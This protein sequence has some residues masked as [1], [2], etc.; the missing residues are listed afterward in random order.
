[1]AEM[2]HGSLNY[3]E[4]D[5]MN[6]FVLT[7]KPQSKDEESL[8]VPQGE[9]VLTED[10]DLVPESLQSAVILLVEDN[11]EML[12]F[13]A[14]KLRQTYAVETALNGKEA[15]NV[16]HEKNI[17]LV[18]SDIMMP[19]MDGLELC[20]RIKE[21]I[22]L[23][24]IPVILLTAKNDLDSK[25]QGLK[26]GADA[27][28][29]KPFAFKY[30]VAQITSI[31]ENRRRGMDAFMRK[32]F[33]PTQTLGMSKADEKLMDKIV[34][35]IEE[36]IDDTNFGVEMLAELVCMSRSSL[37]RKIKAISDSSPTDFIKMVRLKKASELIAEGS[38]RVGEVCYM[39]GINSPSYF[40]KLFQKQF[41]MTPKEFEKQQRKQ[42]EEHKNAPEDGETQS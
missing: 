23:S 38:Y 26:M 3:T 41:G 13:V 32:P 18:L 35:V 5:G 2:L 36:N 20:Q 27:Y 17:D 29:E 37:H 10:D 9:Q 15:L 42:R 7:L 40:I 4:I 11:E 25:V 1:M 28:I 21:D 6:R 24:H 30:L 14:D 12:H 22:E 39:V 19:E 33:V 31:F 8:T 34:Q 16:L